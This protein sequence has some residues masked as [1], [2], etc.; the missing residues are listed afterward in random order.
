MIFFASRRNCT[1]Q[2]LLCSQLVVAFLVQT[3]Q[4]F[5]TICFHHISLFCTCFRKT[6]KS[7]PKKESINSLTSQHLH[8]AIIKNL[9]IVFILLP[10]LQIGSYNLNIQTLNSLMMIFLTTHS[11]KEKHDLF[12]ALQGPIPDFFCSSQ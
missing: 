4:F 9:C 3:L 12:R 8:R 6:V 7:S 10:Y 5:C 1:T 11:L 2:L